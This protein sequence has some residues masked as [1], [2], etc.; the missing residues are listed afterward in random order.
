MA[1]SERLLPRIGLFPRISL[2]RTPDTSIPLA[3]RPELQSGKKGYLIITA[4]HSPDNPNTAFSLGNIPETLTVKPLDLNPDNPGS[5][6]FVVYSPQIADVVPEPFNISDKL[7]RE[8]AIKDASER[9][10][11]LQRRYG[12]TETLLREYP[13]RVILIGIRR[14]ATLSSPVAGT[15]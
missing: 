14:P 5:T 1:L 7:P 13:N 6:D 3:A 11:I 9:A 10:N 8:A 12:F 15:S 2:R 4:L